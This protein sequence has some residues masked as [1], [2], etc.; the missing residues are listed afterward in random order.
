MHRYIIWPSPGALPLHTQLGPT[1]NPHFSPSVKVACYFVPDTSC[2]QETVKFPDH[3]GFSRYVKTIPDDYKLDRKSLLLVLSNLYSC[4][5]FILLQFW[6]S[7]VGIA[8][9]TS[10]VQ[11]CWTSCRSL[12]CCHE[13]LDTAD[14]KH[15][16]R[17]FQR[18]NERY[19]QTTAT[20]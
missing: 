2:Q 14:S 20:V 13:Q 7:F 12:W 4:I 18:I 6:C 16:S 5:V 11:R 1:G 10:P 15:L 3:L 17:L 9:R 8:D 19:E